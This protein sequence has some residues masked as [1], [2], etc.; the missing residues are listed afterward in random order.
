MAIKRTLVGPTSGEALST[1]RVWNGGRASTACPDDEILITENP[2]H[3]H[4]T[5]KA[6][7]R[8][9][10]GTETVV[11]PPDDGALVLTDL[12]IS[13]NKKNGGV[14]TILFTDDVETI[15][16]FEGYV[17]DAPIN[18]TLPFVGRW[19]GWRDARI[20]LTVA[21]DTEVTVAVG[22]MKTSVGLPFAEWDAL[23]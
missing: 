5:F 16:I 12:V 2:F 22:Y 6:T 1:H 4:G 13:A 14:I 10:A 7:T 9:T 17:T 3:A 19:Q 18:I 11:T 21:A 15:T 23:R 20:D 8:S